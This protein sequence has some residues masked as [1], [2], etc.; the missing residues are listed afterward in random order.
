MKNISYIYLSHD[1]SYLLASNSCPGT[2]VWVLD[3]T[4][5]SP[6]NII[7]PKT[8][9]FFPVEMG[10]G[11]VHYKDLLDCGAE[12]R[13]R[14]I[15]PEFVLKTMWNDPGRDRGVGGQ[16][17]DVGLAILPPLPWTAHA[18]CLANPP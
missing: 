10:T 11:W 13:L 2:R 3:F 6:E 15:W 4:L 8:P 1:Y 12:I 18:L 7:F 17:L 5:K 16:A 9:C 14:I